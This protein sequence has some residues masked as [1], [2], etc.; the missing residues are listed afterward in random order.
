MADLISKLTPSSIIIVSISIAILFVLNQINMNKMDTEWV[1]WRGVAQV[2][3][4][5]KYCSVPYEELM[6][7]I[8]AVQERFNSRDRGN[9]LLELL[10]MK[11][12]S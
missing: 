5:V 7:E 1:A 8:N 9:S 4:T 2:A 3:R 6:A 10:A 12:I 11:R